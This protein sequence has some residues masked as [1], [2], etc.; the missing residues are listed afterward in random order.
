M[1]RKSV[2]VAMSGGVDSSTTAALLLK[3]GYNVLGI[4]MVVCPD[5]LRPSVD[6]SQICKI[7]GIEY[8]ILDLKVDFR[9][10]IIDYFAA[11]Y[12]QGRTPNPCTRCNP[13]IKFGKMMNFALE[14]GVDYFATGHYAR[15]IRNHETCLFELHRASF[16]SKD[17]A[18]ALYRLNQEQ[19]SRAMFPLGEISK[20]Q[21]REYARSFGLPVTDK[22]ESQ[23]ICFIPDDDYIKFLK[24]NYPAMSEP[25]PIIHKDGQK[26]GE[27]KG[28]IY[29]TVGQRKRLGISHPK[30]LY[31]LSLD[32]KKNG[33]IVGYWE[34]Q[35]V[36]EAIVGDL[37][38]ISG[39]PPKD[40]RVLVKIRYNQN[41]SPASFEFQSVGEKQ[42]F[43]KLKLVFDEPQR[44][45][46]P[47]QSAVL[48][49]YPDG[50]KVLGGGIISRESLSHLSQLYYS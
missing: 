1:D 33:L 6:A 21:T 38:W 11:E 44:A 19:L 28:L 3:Q 7:L 36:N 46:T 17:Q 24:E 16:H 2:A 26:L 5:Q 40:S 29:Y 41:E 49:S 50:E 27:H 48:Y 25:G 34:D 42:N 18:Y 37:R 10:T 12:K 14:L 22:A 9:K 43:S 23:E 35:F 39:S 45:V 32:A 4:T 15:V 13:R 47:G 8:H 20:N 31:V 30:P